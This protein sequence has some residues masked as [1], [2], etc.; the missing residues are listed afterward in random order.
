MMHLHLGRQVEDCESVHA[1]QA[2]GVAT[3]YLSTA[4]KPNAGSRL[5]F[6]NIRELQ[7][8]AEAVD[9][10]MRGRVASAGD[11]L[12]QRFRAL[13][14]AALEE[15]GWSLA[16]HLELLP[17]AAVSTVS[18]GLRGVMIKAERD[19]LRLR[20]SLRI[21]SPT[22]SLEERG[23]RRTTQSRSVEDPGGTKIEKERPPMRP[24]T[25]EPSPRRERP[26]QRKT[27][28]IAEP[29]EQ[30]RLMV[31]GAE[32]ASIS[33]LNKK[34]P[35]N[36]VCMGRSR[37]PHGNPGGW[38]NPFRA[39]SRSEEC[40]AAALLRCRGYLT[41]PSGRWLRY[42]FHE[43]IEKK[44]FCHC[45]VD[46]MCHVDEVVKVIGEEQE[47]RSR[48]DRPPDLNGMS[49]A[50]VGLALKSHLLAPRS[51]SA[52][53]VERHSPLSALFLPDTRRNIALVE[54]RESSNWPR[55]RNRGGT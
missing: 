3:A 14:A 1:V 18:S 47:A 28:E 24:A 16:R 34:L 50:E 36:S 17:D 30:A 48:D 21:R 53:S 27:K 49:L 45:S 46:E 41:S 13:E 2:K 43:L 54:S 37:G 44:C 39:Q 8:L 32:R 23:R 31:C 38:G 5:G 51:A 42:Q 22:P 6:R 7:S 4:L 20:Q 19:S 25:E 52:M 29:A 15:G 26:E 33:D 10:P 9:L 35:P 40:R 11:V 55:Q 12:I